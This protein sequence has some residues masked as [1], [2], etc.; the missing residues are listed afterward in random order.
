MANIEPQ[1]LPVNVTTDAVE[2]R[3][4]DEECF[5]CY[6]LIVWAWEIAWARYDEECED[7]YGVWED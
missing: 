7:R 6:P 3:C 4:A 2:C 5:F 1:S